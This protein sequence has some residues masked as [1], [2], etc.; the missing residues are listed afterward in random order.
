MAFKFIERKIHK[1]DTKYL[2]IDNPELIKELGLKD[3]DIKI[4]RN[5]IL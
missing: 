1:Q 4:F 5:D 3:G 2:I